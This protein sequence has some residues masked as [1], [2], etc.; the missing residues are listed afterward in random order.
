MRRNFH[1]VVEDETYY[2]VLRAL[3]ENPLGIKPGF[4]MNCSGITNRNVLDNYLIRLDRTGIMIAESDDGK[5]FIPQV[6]EEYLASLNPK[7]PVDDGRKC[8][9]L[10]DART[11]M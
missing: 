2:R 8:G 4:A 10:L 1:P 6:R 7:T 11:Y 3:V 9:K 5:L